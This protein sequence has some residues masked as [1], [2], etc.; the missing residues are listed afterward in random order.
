MAFVHEMVTV[1]GITQKQAAINAGCSV[2]RA[3][4][5]SC[6]WMRD[7]N[8]K[9]EIDRQ[10]A[11]KLGAIEKKASAELTPATV[12]EDLDDIAEMCKQAGP[13]AWQAATLVKVAELK[14]KYLKMFTDRVEVGLDDVLIQKLMEGR[15][16]ASAEPPVIEAQVVAELPAEAEVAN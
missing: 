4:V 15:K 7:P 8:I 16:R 6:E 10:L 3:A 13:G 2:K 14:G 5:T 9:R 11:A 12:I 1:P